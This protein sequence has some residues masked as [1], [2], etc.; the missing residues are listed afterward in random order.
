MVL[1]K[2][3]D[4]ADTISAI[5]EGPLVNNSLIKWLEV[6]IRGNY[7]SADEDIRWVY[8][9]VLYLWPDVELGSDSSGYGSS[10]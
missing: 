9:Q 5:M 3:V 10:G 7:Q 6:I 2:H 8:K 4:A 1:H